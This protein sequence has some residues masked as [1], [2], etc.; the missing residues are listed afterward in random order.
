[1]KSDISYNG[2]NVGCLVEYSPIGNCD[3]VWEYRTEGIIVGIKLMG[4][5]AAW[6]KI[7]QTKEMEHIFGKDKYFIGDITT[8]G[9]GYNWRSINTLKLLKKE[10]EEAMKEAIVK[11]FEKTADAVLVE[12]HLGGQ[13]K[14]D[15]MSGLIV[16]QN[17]VEILTEAK[18]LEAEEVAKADKE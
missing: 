18:R 8:I 3:Y 15:F 1:M 7:K 11:N 16:K 4:G 10:V 2:F 5:G 9:Y 12:K 14:D 13:I 17:K 6:I